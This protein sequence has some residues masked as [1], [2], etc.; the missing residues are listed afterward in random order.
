MYRHISN[1][2]KDYIPFN[3]SCGVTYYEMEFVESVEPIRDR[4]LVLAKKNEIP[5]E[6]LFIP[7]VK[8]E[9]GFW[10]SIINIS[11]FKNCTTTFDEEEGDDYATLRQ[12]K[13]FDRK[14]SINKWNTSK[15]VK[16]FYLSFKFHRD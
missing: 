4:L 12:F 14:S 1:N 2:Y 6:I 8:I 9:E 5:T 13:A 3:D 16:I 10:D 11:V 7:R 15:M